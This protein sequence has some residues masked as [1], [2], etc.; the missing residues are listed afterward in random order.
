MRAAC[1]AAIAALAALS[2]LGQAWAHTTVEVGPYEIEVGWGT[3]PPIE[4]MRNTVVYSITEAAGG[5]GVRRGV[6]GS[7]AGLDA[8]LAFGGVEREAE[9][10]ND[11][12]PG[13]YYTKI[14][15]TRPGSY[16]VHVSGEISGTAVDEEIRIEDVERTAALDFPP[17]GASGGDDV[18][19]LRA[20]VSAMQ[21][22]MPSGGAPAADPVA[23]DI[24]V[25]GVAFGVAGIALA[26]IALLKRR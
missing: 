4:G 11:A 12:R 9:V 14:I 1:V 13:H 26:T 6:A 20:A 2:G 5:E 10:L 19:A 18:A 21:R 3:E 8:T 24:A 16:H 17:R 23:Y 7:F 25:F 15:P 22:G